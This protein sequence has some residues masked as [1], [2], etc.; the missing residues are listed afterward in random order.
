MPRISR[1]LADDSIYHVINRGNGGQV[2]F[3]KDKDY[4]A[5][6]NFMKEAKI[7]YTVRIFAYCLMPN[8]FHIV[9][10]PHESEDLSK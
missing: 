2:V 6:V 4:E 8:H 9:V 10:M 1:G 3:Q 5:C 7:R